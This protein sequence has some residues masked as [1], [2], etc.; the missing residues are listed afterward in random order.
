V[1]P[2]VKSH[3][4]GND[5]LVLDG[6]VA[7]GFPLEP[8]AIRRLCHRNLG[9]GSDGILVRVDPPAGDFGVRIFNP[10]GSEAEK[11]GNGLRIFA[12][13]LMEHGGAEQ[14]A[15]TVWTRGGVVG[16][17]CRLEA[18]R[19]VAVAVEMG[20]ASFRARDVPMEGVDGEAVSV[21]LRLEDD[22]LTVTA[23]SVGNP[24]CVVFRDRL[25]PHE[26]ERIGPGLERHAA[27][28]ERTN[29]QVARPERRD[30][31]AVLVWERGA[32]PTLASGSSACAVAAAAVR[33]GHC[34]PG[35]V[36]IRMPGGE[37]VVEVRPDWTLRLTGPVEEV[38]TGTL[39]PELTRALRASA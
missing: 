2:F 25:D 8:G 35:S 1:I 29:V 38:A 27:F 11:S 37:L 30:R 5:Y 3:G 6:R 9:L 10:D 24:H 7:L 22:V 4:L 17:A 34:D 18:G 13:Y 36:T 26:L 31:V 14:T 12:K 33:V 19:V 28:P 32:G 20:R 21:P 23:L 16:C 15:F 39:S